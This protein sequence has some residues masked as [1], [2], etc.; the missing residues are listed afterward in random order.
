MDVEKLFGVYGGVILFGNV[1]EVPNTISVL[2]VLDSP[3]WSTSKHVAVCG[4]G[5]QS[6]AAAG[7]GGAVA[8]LE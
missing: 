8:M 1:E 7:G 3:H 4:T 2:V 5:V 6:V